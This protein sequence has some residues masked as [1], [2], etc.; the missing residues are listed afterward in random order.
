MK[1]VKIDIDTLGIMTKYQNLNRDCEL[2]LWLNNKLI[3]T[4]KP[5][6]AY[7]MALIGPKRN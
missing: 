4:L 2:V 6:E 5:G 1:K 7:L 3:A